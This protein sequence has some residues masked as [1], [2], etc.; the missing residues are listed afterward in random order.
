M[1]DK[2][3]NNEP[4]KFGP[5][6]EPPPTPLR[7]LILILIPIGLTIITYMILSRVFG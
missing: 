3:P 4:K 1:S 2:T 5:Q 6:Y 7:G